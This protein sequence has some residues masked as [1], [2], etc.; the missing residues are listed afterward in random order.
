[1]LTFFPELSDTLSTNKLLADAMSQSARTHG[2]RL[3]QDDAK[4]CLYLSC[5]R[6][7]PRWV[8]LIFSTLSGPL[9]AS[10]SVA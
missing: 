7:L 8:L 3:L 6:R 2:Q 10:Y 5:R 9:Y 1:M 4:W